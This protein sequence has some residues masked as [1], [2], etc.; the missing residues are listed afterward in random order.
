MSK[1]YLTRKDASR[2]KESKIRQQIAFASGIFQADVTIR[3]LLE[4]LA[5]GIVIIDNSGTI[6]LV[7]SRAEQMFGY[8][9][10]VLVG[11][12]HAVL[13]PERFRNVHEEH[14]AHFFAEPKIRPMGLLL[15]LTGLRR[16]GSEFPL[17]IS[18]SFLETINGVLV[19]AFISDITLRK[20]YE[21]HLRETEELFHIQVE[22]VKDYAIFMLDTQGNVLNWNAGAERL[23][24]YTEKEIIGTYF[25]CFYTDEDRKAGKPEEILK[26]ADAE[27]RA[28]DEGWRIRKGGH[29]F[30]ADVIITALYNENR[31]LRGF[32][33]VTRNV[34]EQKQAADALRE[35]ET[36]YR[37]LFRDNPT[38]IVT[39]DSDWTMLSV[40]PICASQLGYTIDELEGQTV[41]KLFHE[42]DHPAVAE[43]L[44]M[45]L[46]NPDQIYRWQIRKIRKDGGLLWVEE[47]AQAMYDQNGALIVLVVCQDVTE[48]KRVEEERERLLLQF[49]AVLENINEGV[50]ISDLDGNMLAMNKAA[51]ALHEF[52][53]I[54]QVRRPL[55]EYQDTFEMFDLEGRPTP[56]EEWPMARVLRGDR[57]VDYEVRVRHKGTGK[58]WVGSYSGTQV[59][60][61]SGDIILTVITVR[62]ISERKFAEEEIGRLNVGLTAWAAE[63]DAANK[64]L[65]AFNYTVAHDLRNPLNVISMS[66]QAIKELYGD[67]LQEECLEYI[68]DVHN[69][70]LH[71][72]RLI[73]ALLNFSRMG[74]VE[75]HREKVLLDVPAHEVAT[76]LKKTEPERQVDFRITDGITADADANL[77]RV[78][79]DNLLGN[80]W[81]YTG[82]QEKA[83]IEVGTTDIDGKPVYFVRDNG[84][85]FD[86]A[87]ADKLFMP[88]QRLP[89]AETFKGSGIG[90]ATVERIVKRHGGTIWAEGAPGNGA[91]FY[92]TLQRTEPTA[93]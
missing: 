23:K 16:D 4:S 83:V 91:C 2:K 26:K 66:C 13:I 58:S 44:R 68:R 35:S 60:N 12:P 76:M 19:M 33:V 22:G 27:G 80:A 88:F 56:F 7:N 20:R 15:D 92:F 54:E 17:E 81:K 38:M 78:V 82:M 79:L 30:W 90:L 47:T 69:G 29:R 62:D 21:S 6:L 32:S 77:V 36:R 87:T 72:N 1:P 37:A 14:M 93:R 25:S 10:K 70:V 49:E 50:V 55:S 64:D 86:K 42:D 46:Q 34:T 57:Y 40:N 75:L 63:L 41:L 74:H 43:Q 18:L 11:K 61:T 31:Y 24:G 51:L 3:T 8:P 89:G 65:E 85:G 5:E 71:M 39:L 28:A 48:R 45:C 59:R 84:A 53:S 73:E 9:D 67:Q 52:E